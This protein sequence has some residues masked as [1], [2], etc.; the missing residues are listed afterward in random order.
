MR[1]FLFIFVLV[2]V[3]CEPSKPKDTNSFKPDPKPSVDTLIPTDT[4]TYWDEPTGDVGEFIAKEFITTMIDSS[5][6]KNCYDSLF[7]NNDETCR[8]CFLSLSITMSAVLEDEQLVFAVMRTSIKPEVLRLGFYDQNNQLDE[9][10]IAIWVNYIRLHFSLD[11][12]Q[13][14]L[15]EMLAFEGKD[16]AIDVYIEKLK[17]FVDLD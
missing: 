1:Y 9:T 7:S 6:T 15:S 13:D 17:E 12:Q 2:L 3:G 4:S 16:D 8:T 11:Q 10:M 5:N 14:Y